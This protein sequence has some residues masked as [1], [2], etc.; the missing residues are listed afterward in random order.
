MFNRVSNT[1]PVRKLSNKVLRMM[2]GTAVGLSMTAATFAAP[3]YAALPLAEPM[4]TIVSVEVISA[5]TSG[6]VDVPVV[7]ESDGSVGVATVEVHYDS[8]VLSASECAGN[9]EEA[10]QMGLCN[11]DYADGVVRFNIADP[12]GVS[13]THTLATI[14][15]DVLEGELAEDVTLKIEV[16]EFTDQ[17]ANVMEVRTVSGD[18]ADSSLPSSGDADST[19]LF[20]PLILR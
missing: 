4:E 13:G 15:F 16:S 14:T 1:D 6:S 5:G 9:P 11:A 19:F 8:S 3:A 20:L 7:V 18:G 10:F 12:E 2:L 17:D